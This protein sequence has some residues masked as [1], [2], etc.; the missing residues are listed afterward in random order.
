MTTYTKAN[1]P[2]LTAEVAHHMLQIRTSLKTIEQLLNN[3][4][5][6][7]RDTFREYL[8]TAVLLMQSCEVSAT[9][10]AVA[11]TRTP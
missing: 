6:F 4:D 5:G 1:D 11:K 3:A 2:A 10:F 8:Q 9:Q 7:R